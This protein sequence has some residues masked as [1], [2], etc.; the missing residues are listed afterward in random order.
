MLVVTTKKELREARRNK[1]KSFVIRGELAKELLAAEQKRSMK[2][3]K[4]DSIGDFKLGNK[5]GE[6]RV[7]TET[8]VFF[9]LGMTAITSIT[10]IVLYALKKDYDVKLRVKSKEPTTGGKDKKKGEQEIE[11]VCERK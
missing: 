4:A 10:L 5:V 11:L 9:A 1:T 8:M 7:I 3:N 2:N 6:Q